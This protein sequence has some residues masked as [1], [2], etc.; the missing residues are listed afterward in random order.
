[1][2]KARA[3]IEAKAEDRDARVKEAVRDV[4]RAASLKVLKVET[5]QRY[6]SRLMRAAAR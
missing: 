6:V 5:A 3:A 1:M 4:Q 2:K